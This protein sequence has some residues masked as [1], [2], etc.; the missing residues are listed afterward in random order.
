MIMNINCDK[1]I[2]ELEGGSDCIVVD[3]SNK[4]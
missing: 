3:Q 4:I 1:Y 2:E